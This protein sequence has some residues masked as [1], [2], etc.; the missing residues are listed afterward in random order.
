MQRV[1]KCHQALS[2]SESQK[3]ARLDRSYRIRIRI[4]IRMPLRYT[5]IGVFLL[6][7]R[8]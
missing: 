1:G 3:V 6:S 8:L 4:R 2:K 7:S 5:Y